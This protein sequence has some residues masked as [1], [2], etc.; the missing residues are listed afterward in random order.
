MNISLNDGGQW[1]YS[2]WTGF[3]LEAAACLTAKEAKQI[4]S[5]LQIESRLIKL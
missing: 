1:R 5:Q 2:V 4:K 3:I